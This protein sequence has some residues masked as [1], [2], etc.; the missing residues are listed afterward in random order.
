MNSNFDH[1]TARS[2]PAKPYRPKARTSFFMAIVKL[3]VHTPSPEKVVAVA[4]RMCYSKFSFDKIWTTMTDEE[5]RKGVQLLNNM[6]H[7]SPVEH[8]SFTFSIAGI[9][10]ACMAQ[11]TRHRMASFSVKSQRYVDE[12]RF[13]FVAPPTAKDDAEYQAIMKRLHQAYTDLKNQGHPNEDARFVLPNACDTQL[14]A[15]MNARS[16]RN[17]FSLRCCYRAQ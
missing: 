5:V 10:R 2:F 15:T 13:K 4:A 11:I 17:F 12:K 1:L 6:H 8:A 16:L 9:S 14:I 3:I 7:Q